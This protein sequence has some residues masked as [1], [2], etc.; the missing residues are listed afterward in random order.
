[1]IIGLVPFLGLALQNVRSELARV[2]RLAV[3]I[4]NHVFFFGPRR[5]TAICALFLFTQ[6]SRVLFRRWIDVWVTHFT[7][8][9]CGCWSTNFST[10]DDTS[11][12]HS[13]HKQTACVHATKHFCPDVT[14]RRVSVWVCADPSPPRRHCAAQHAVAYHYLFRPRGKAVVL[15]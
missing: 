2:C 8:A 1:M 14:G 5:F 12:N 13:W 15:G 3:Q 6:P 9:T 11:R 4:F 10:F 7:S